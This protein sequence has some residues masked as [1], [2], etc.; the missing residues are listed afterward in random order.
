MVMT[1]KNNIKFTT[2]KSKRININTKKKNNKITTRKTRKNK[3]KSFPKLLEKR[4]I[5]SQSGSGLFFTSKKDKLKKKYK[6]YIKIIEDYYFKEL[7]DTI[8]SKDFDKSYKYSY[9]KKYLKILN[10]KYRRLLS[11]CI[12]KILILLYKKDK[13]RKSSNIVTSS[14]QSKQGEGHSLYSILDENKSNIV[15]GFFTTVFEDKDKNIHTLDNL[16]DENIKKYITELNKS[17]S[18]YNQNKLFYL[19]SNSS[20]DRHSGHSNKKIVALIVKDDNIHIINNIF[21]QI[22]FYINYLKNNKGNNS[23]Q[24]ADVKKIQVM[25]KQ[26]FDYLCSHTP[27]IAEFFIKYIKYTV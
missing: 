1:K 10:N 25:L 8:N 3:Y 17:N 15:T 20:L 12:N 23:K 14:D 4:T 16:N 11:K 22:K 2:M 26:H 24:K 13:Y 6:A 5:K 7:N 19:E 9:Q 18:N 21:T 27:T